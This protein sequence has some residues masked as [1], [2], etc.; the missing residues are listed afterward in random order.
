MMKSCLDILN[1]DALHFNM[2][3]VESSYLMNQ[4]VEDLVD[5]ISEEVLYACRWFASHIP[6]SNLGAWREND[7]EISLKIC[8]FFEN[9][10]FYWLEV[11]STSDSVGV[12]SGMLFMIAQ[13][14]LVSAFMSFTSPRLS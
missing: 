4:E 10:F 12:A 3:E 9:K 13:S 8:S 6:S 5:R 11:M 1:S 14:S 7:D 2:G